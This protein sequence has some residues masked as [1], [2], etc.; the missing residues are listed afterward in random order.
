MSESA[1]RAAATKAC[2]FGLLAAACCAAVGWLLLVGPPLFSR[3][4]ILAS[5]TL[6]VLGGLARISRVR[7]ARSA[8]DFAD[9]A[10]LPALV[11]FGPIWAMFV[12]LPST[13]HRDPLRTTFVISVDVLKLV[14][15]GATFA[16]FSP[17]LLFGGSFGWSFAYG[18]AA[19][20]LVFYALDALLNSALVR[21]KYGTSLV[22]VLAESFLPLI[23]SDMVAIGTALATAYAVPAFGWPAAVIIP[24]GCV[25][26]YT[27]LQDARERTAEMHALRL[28]NERLKKEAREANL[29]FAYRLVE[30]LGEKDGATPRLAAATAVYA[31]DLAGEF[32]LS[33][34]RAAKLGI[35]ALLIDAGLAGL[36]D[37]VL[38][39][40]PDKLNSV[41]KRLLEEH[42]IRSERLLA[43][44]PG[45]EEAAKWARWH[46]ERPDGTGY[47]DRVKGEW[48]PLETKILTAASSWSSLILDW[49]YRPAL[50]P[51]EARKRFIEELGW[52][53]DQE[54]GRALLRLIDIEGETYARAADERFSL[55]H[56]AQDATK[57]LEE[58]WKD[59]SPQAV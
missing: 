42:P 20:S 45:Y 52:G 39:T 21:I 4:A 8:T 59:T 18:T 22:K 55:P 7:F 32:G 54:V 33:P 30:N 11:L 34:D 16:W 6:A 47:P 24:A 38:S 3:E 37:E 41:G 46:H 9:A 10:V 5:G 40:S 14:A 12:E 57:K 28:E 56:R 51:Q 25:L 13:L 58:Q 36:P 44:A 43:A 49:P 48:I 17:P 2:V 29:T 27:L 35:A 1:T 50:T 31:S 15:A 26:S 23:P 53:I 19:A